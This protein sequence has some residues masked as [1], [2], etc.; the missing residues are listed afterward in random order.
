MTKI[1]GIGNTTQQH[2]TNSTAHSV[3][4]TKAAMSYECKIS[5][6]QGPE[7]LGS[8]CKSLFAV[9]SVTALIACV[10]LTVAETRHGASAGTA[11]C[12]EAIGR[13]DKV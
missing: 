4:I 9:G 3:N 11:E 7:A 12:L 8:C 10:V 1:W 2:T 6:A 13:I 5:I